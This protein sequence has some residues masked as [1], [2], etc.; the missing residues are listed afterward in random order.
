MCADATLRGSDNE[1]AAV[2]TQGLWRLG[3][4]QYRAFECGGPIYLR[5]THNDGSRERLG[6]HDFLKVAEGAIF[7]RDNRLGVHAFP[8]NANASADVWQEIAFLSA[9]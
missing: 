8:P 6:P 7:T 1:I 4:R 5:V 3:Q 2:Y 9:L